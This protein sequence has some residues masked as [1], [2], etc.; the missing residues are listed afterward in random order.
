MP[1][2]GYVV[3]ALVGASVGVLGLSSAFRD[4]VFLTSASPSM[5]CCHLQLMPSF[6][7]NYATATAREDP[8]TGS[9]TRREPVCQPATV[10]H[11]EPRIVTS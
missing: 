5:R 7:K 9:L 8:A 11:L 1:V 3:V 4:T 6:L 10:Q 2:A